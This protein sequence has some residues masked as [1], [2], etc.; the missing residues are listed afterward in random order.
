MASCVFSRYDKDAAELVFFKSNYKKTFSFIISEQF[1]K[2]NVKS[3]VSALSST[4]NVAELK[5]LTKFLKQNKHCI[6]KNG[7]LSFRVMSKQ[8]T[9]YDVTFNSV[10]EQNYNAKP[11]SPATYF[12]QCL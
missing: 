12:G 10:I 11:I 5:L 9:V 6:D 1:V 4:M 8:E 2:N 3:K 7:E